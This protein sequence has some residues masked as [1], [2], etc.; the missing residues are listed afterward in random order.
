MKHII[1]HFE[2]LT[3][4]HKR[5][6]IQELQDLYDISINLDLISSLK[7]QLAESQQEL[8]K[9][10]AYITELEEQ[11]SL[12]SKEQF[13]ASLSKIERTTYK[14]KIAAEFW[15]ENMQKRLS[16]LEFKV[17]TKQKNYDSL[18]ENYLKVLKEN[19]DLKK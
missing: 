17:K 4:Q 12:K 8:G 7:K 15:Y 6:L 13:W 16:L 1:Q 2:R 14:E 3:P 19:E 9:A 18:L 10:Q 11:I 5:A